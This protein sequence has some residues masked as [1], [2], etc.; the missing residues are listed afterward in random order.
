[1]WSKAVC[2][3]VAGRKKEERSQYSF[4]GHISNDLNSYIE[5][6]TLKIA[7]Y[8][9]MTSQAGD[10][11]LNIWALGGGVLI[12]PT[13]MIKSED[14]PSNTVFKKNFRSESLPS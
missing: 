4:H 7:L 13:S 9:P 11:I 10:Q 2:L 8:F 1:M 6:S 3:M 12:K 5:V 14:S